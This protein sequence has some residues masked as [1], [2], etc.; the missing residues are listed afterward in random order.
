MSFASLKVYFEFFRT[1][2]KLGIFCIPIRKTGLTYGDTK[3]TELQIGSEEFEVDFKGCKR[4][5]DWLKISL[6]YEKSDKHTTI[7]DS[8]NVK[9]AAKV[10]QNIELIFPMPIAQQTQ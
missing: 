4:Q 2:L 9:F 6:V 8:Y 1:Y 7:Y 3:N 5:F 10:I